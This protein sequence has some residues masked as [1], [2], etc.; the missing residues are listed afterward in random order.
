ML[1]V[2]WEIPQGKKKN[3]SSFIK[4]V[5]DLVLVVRLLV[6]YPRSETISIW[7]LLGD[8]LSHPSATAGGIVTE[9]ILNTRASTGL[10]AESC[11]ERER[12]GGKDGC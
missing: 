9:G 1:N 10:E 7:S 3:R 6:F 5:L 8:Y 2:S 4:D 11:A 12:L